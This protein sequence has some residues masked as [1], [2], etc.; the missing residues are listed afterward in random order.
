VADL[1]KEPEPVPIA[2]S[3]TTRWAAGAVGL[4]LVGLITLFAVGSGSDDTD[5]NDLLGGRVP[6]VAGAT[7][8]GGSYDID[9]S[10]GSWVLVNFF[11]TWC[12][13]C[14]AEHPELVAFDA[15]GRETGRAEVVAVVF[16]D[17]VEN[18]AAFFA[19][20]GGGWPVL[21]QP[22][23]SLEFQVMQVPESFLVSPS[24]QVV[25]HVQGEVTA[26]ALID[27]IE[28]AP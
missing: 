11:A 14:I 6:E 18:V 28:S 15:W 20:N 24:G 26:D 19:E 3:H 8:D 5:T 13:P 22:S 16:N 7:L 12:P 21:D 1:E 27:L 10:R 9:D 17:P 25:Q 4:V 23:L 2:V